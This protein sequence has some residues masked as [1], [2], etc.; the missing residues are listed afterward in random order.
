MTAPS[1]LSVTVK[2]PAALADAVSSRMR[3]CVPTLLALDGAL[4]VGA[5]VVAV[6]TDQ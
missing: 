3:T 2:R 4:I 5:G 1:T 6:V